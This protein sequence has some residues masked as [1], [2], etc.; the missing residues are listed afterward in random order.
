MIAKRQPYKII[1]YPNRRNIG[2]VIPHPYHEPKEGE[3]IAATLLTLIGG[4]VKFLP[5]SHIPNIKNPDC[6]WQKTI[7]E[8]KTLYGNSKNNTE[9]VI[10]DA[11]KQSFYIIINASL[12]SRSIER[13][14]IDVLHC[15]TSDHKNSCIKQVLVLGRNHYSIIKRSMLK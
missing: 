3:D 4:D 11:R 8:I 5:E 2:K 1:P 14:M 12:T 9:N 15:L 7:W 13:V 6:E 10:R